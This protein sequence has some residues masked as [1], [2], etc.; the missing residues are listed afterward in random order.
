[1]GEEEEEGGTLTSLAL[2]EEVVGDAN[3]DEASDAASNFAPEVMNRNLIFLLR[4]R[5]I[6]V[7][8]MLYAV[9]GFSYSLWIECI[10]LWLIL[11][12]ARY[13]LAM[14]SAELGIPM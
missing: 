11:R 14:N 6:W 4:Q 7:S 13:G 12:P 2:E 1:M 8:C 5:Q 9:I 3:D 10:P